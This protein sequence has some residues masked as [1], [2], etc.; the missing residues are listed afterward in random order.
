MSELEGMINKCCTRGGYRLSD[1]NGNFYCIL[2]QNINEA[3]LCEYAQGF[4]YIQKSR[5]QRGT[6]VPYI[7]CT[8]KVLRH[9]EGRL[10]ID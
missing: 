5:G 9:K 7:E 4:I 2:L 3:E 1:R 8:R 10:V 6:R